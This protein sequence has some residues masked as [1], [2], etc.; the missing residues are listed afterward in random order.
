MHGRRRAEEGRRREA[1]ERS[2][3]FQPAVS[4]QRFRQGCVA[5]LKSERGGEKEQRGRTLSS[6]HL[7]GL[8]FRV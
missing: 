3:S 4:D 5:R 2:H 8:G 7:S 1:A 6:L